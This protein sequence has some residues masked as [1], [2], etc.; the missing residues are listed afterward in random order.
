MTRLTDTSP[1]AER[2]LLDVYR[3]MSPG[4]K[5]L[6]L[7]QMFRDARALHAAGMRLRNPAVT[8]EEIHRDWLVVNLGFTP[9]DA[10]RGPAV[11]EN[12]ANLSGLREVITVLDRLGIAYALGGSLASSLYGIGRFTRDAD[13]TV[14]PFPGREAP[15]AAAFG[16][17]YYVSLPAIQDAV[18]R[19]SSFNIINTSTGFKV[20]VFVHPDEPFELAAMTRR[21]AVLLP[22]VPEQPLVFHSAEDT[23]L[24]KLRWYRLGNESSEQQLQDVRGVLRVQAGKLDDAYLDQWAAQLQVSDLLARAR[25]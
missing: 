12:L 18:R 11:D 21:V 6:Q 25:G 23:I 20:D 15:L 14:E 7:G 24:F 16:P 13:L 5:W 10:I 4:Q 2:V 1:E 19:R 8:P 9:A 3:R 17:D 22:D